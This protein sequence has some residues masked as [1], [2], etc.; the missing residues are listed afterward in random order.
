MGRGTIQLGC[1]SLSLGRENHRI[2]DTCFASKLR[3]SNYTASIEWDERILGIGP[4]TKSN[5][6]NPMGRTRGLNALG[7]EK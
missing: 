2:V 7:E 5:S 1:E 3:S 4:H 6:E